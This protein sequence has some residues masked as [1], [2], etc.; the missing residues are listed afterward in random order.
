MELSFHSLCSS[1][2]SNDCQLITSNVNDGYLKF[3]VFRSAVSGQKNLVNR[4]LNLF[5]SL[6][7][8]LIQQTIYKADFFKKQ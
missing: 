2:E 7:C 4:S 3:R 8:E 5:C 6:N 1:E